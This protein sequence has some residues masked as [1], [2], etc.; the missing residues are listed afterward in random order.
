MLKVSS[1]LSLTKRILQCFNCDYA[2]FLVN[3]NK[4]RYTIVTV[5]KPIET[6]PLRVEHVAVCEGDVIDRVYQS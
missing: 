5:G 1:S 3:I 2:I 4:Y 6:L